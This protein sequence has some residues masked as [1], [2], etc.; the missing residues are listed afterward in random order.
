MNKYVEKEINMEK[1]I[2]LHSFFISTL[3]GDG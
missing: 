1:E 2:K 3:F